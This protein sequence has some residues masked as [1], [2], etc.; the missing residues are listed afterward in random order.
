MYNCKYLNSHVCDCDTVQVIALQC[1]TVYYTT[2]HYTML[3]NYQLNLRVLLSDTPKYLYF[4]F[5]NIFIASVFVSRH[6]LTSNRR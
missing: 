2:L 4:K 6:L 1:T 3:H 5:F